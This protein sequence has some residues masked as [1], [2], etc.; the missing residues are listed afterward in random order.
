MEKIDYQQE[1]LDCAK[2]FYINNKLYSRD[3]I[4]QAVLKLKYQ[5]KINEECKIFDVDF[6]S[7][8]EDMGQKLLKEI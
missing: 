7:Y 4:E 1:I 5:E 2:L 3:C 6:Y 8:C